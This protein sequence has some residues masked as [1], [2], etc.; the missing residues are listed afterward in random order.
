MQIERLKDII[1]SA[2]MNFYLALACRV[3][4]SLLLEK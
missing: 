4:I 1:Q 2:N 3:H